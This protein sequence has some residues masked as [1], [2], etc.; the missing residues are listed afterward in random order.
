M[1]FLFTIQ[2]DGGREY[3]AG[4]IKV[5]IPRK[6]I[7]AFLGWN[8]SPFRSDKRYDRKF[9][10]SLLIIFRRVITVEAVN[11]EVVQF[12]RKLLS[13]RVQDDIDRLNDLDDYIKEFLLE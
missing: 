7:E 3:I 10:R 4:T 8:T 6:V 1:Y 9:V 12:I 11:Q 2:F 5:T 13:I